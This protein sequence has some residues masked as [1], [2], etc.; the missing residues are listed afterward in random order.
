MM[1][2]ALTMKISCRAGSLAIVALAVLASALLPSTA[3]SYC[4]VIPQPE[5]EF[6]GAAGS[7]NRVFASPGDPVRI[8]LDPAGCESGTSFGSAATLSDFESGGL[9]AWATFGTHAFF[10]NAGRNPPPGRVLFGGD[11]SAGDVASLLAPSQ[12]LGD[13]LARGVNRISWEHWTGFDAGPYLTAP[14]ALIR[15]EGPGGVAEY[16]ADQAE[17]SAIPFEQWGSG[18]DIPIS[19]AGPTGNWQLVSGSWAALL[20]DVDELRILAELKQAAN[21][22]WAIDNFTLHDSASPATTTVLFEPPSGPANAVIIPG[23][24]GD[25]TAFVSQVAACNASLGGGTATCRDDLSPSVQADAIS[26]AFPDTAFVGPTTLAVS[27]SGAALPCALATTECGGPGAPGGLVACIDRIYASDGTCEA[28]P[29]NAHEQFAGVTA[30]PAPNDF[31]DI[32][33]AGNPSVSC[34]NSGADVQ[35]TTDAEGNLVIPVDWRGVLVQPRT[36]PIPRLVQIQSS[37]AA[38]TG[39]PPEAN[40]T[41][42]AP[43]E[44]PGARFLQSLSQ[45]GLRVDPLFNPLSNPTSTD[46]TLFGSTD[47]EIGVIRVLRR[48]PEFRECAA[49]TRGG[50]ACIA[51]FECPS[52][53]CVQALCR[54]GVNDGVACTGDGACPGGEC[55]PSN[56]D[57]SDRYSGGTGP[58]L[59]ASAEYTAEAL[60]PVAIESLAQTD[61]LFAFVRSER[62]EST[63]LNLD[64]DSTDETIIDLKI[65]D[66]AD[67]ADIARRVG[68]T[69]RASARVRDGIYRFPPLAIEDDIAAFLEAERWESPSVLGGLNGDGDRLDTL[70]RVFRIETPAPT[71]L[72][73][74]LDLAVDP[75]AD[76]NGQTLAVSDG[77][78]FFRE[79]ER[80]GASWQVANRSFL[81]DELR[82]SSNQR[83]IAYQNETSSFLEVYDRDDDLD[84]IL[85]EGFVRITV[86]LDTL[87]NPVAGDHHI[88]DI[89]A[90]GRY[91]AFSSDA[92][93][94][95]A[96]DTNGSDDVF[97]HDRDTDEDGIYDEPGFVANVRVSVSSAGVQANNGSSRP[98]MSDDGRFVVFASSATNMIAGDAFLDSELVIHDRDTDEDGIYDE[99]GAIA[100]YR[101]SDAV[102]GVGV[103]PNDDLFTPAEMSRDGRYV[104]FRS[105]ASNLIAGDTNLRSDAFILDRDLDGDGI[106]DESGEA[107]FVSPSLLDTQ[108]IIPT[109]MSD[110]GRVIMGWQPGGLAVIYD[111][112]GDDDGI[113]D[114]PGT[115]SREEVGLSTLGFDT[116]SQGGTL[117]SDGRYALVQPFY[118]G[119]HPSGSFAPQFVDRVTRIFSFFPDGLGNQPDTSGQIQGDAETVFHAK[120]LPG[121]RY[122]RKPA[123][124]G[125]SNDLN[126]DGDSRDTVLAV[127]D[128]QAVGPFTV[129]RFGSA[130]AVS[131]RDGNAAFLADESAAGAGVDHNGDGDFDDLVVQLYRNRQ[132]GPA[133]NLAL[134]A[135]QVAVSSQVV[136]ALASEAQEGLFLNGDGDMDDLVVHLNDTATG[137][138][139]TWQNLFLAADDVQTVGGFVAFTVPEADQGAALNGDGDQL[140]RVLHVYDASGQP[141]A[142]LDDQGVARFNPAVDDFVL[143]E[144]IIA[145]RVSEEGEGVNLNGVVPP[146]VGGVADGDLFDSV[147]HVMDLSTGRTYNGMQAAIPC[148]VEACDPRIPYRVLG[149]KVSFLTLEAQ[150]GGNDLDQS[151]GPLN[152]VIQHFNPEALI[153]GGSMEDA[154]DIV[155]GAVAGICTVT[156]AGCASNAD[157]SGGGECYFPPGGCLFDTGSGC[158]PEVPD[159][160]PGDEFCS[161]VLG[162][163][164]SFTCK[165]ITGPCLTDAECAATE[166]CVDDGLNPEALFATLEEAEDGR[167]RYVTRGRCSDGDGSCD[168]DSQCNEGATCDLGTTTIATAADADGDGLADPIDN[169]QDVANG[170]QL[171]VDGDGIGDAC[172]RQ[173]CGNGIQE[174]G[175]GCDHGSQNGIDGVCDSLCAYVGGG[176]ACSDGIDNDGDGLVDLADAGCDDGADTSERSN[177]LVCDDGRDNDGDYGSDVG[178]DPGCIAPD[179]AREDPACSDGLDNDADGFTD[180]DGGG[181]G[182]PDPQCNGNPYVAKEKAGGCGLGPELIGLLG[183]ARLRRR[184]TRP[185]GSKSAA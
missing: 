164:G 128:T 168:N 19:S 46:T 66:S 52:S 88:G 115:V 111:R 74:G 121:G 185:E 126:G 38:F 75:I 118:F 99:P 161:P 64:G 159:S 72:T 42:G 25:C 122:L 146:I 96:G 81:G 119:G 175:E 36:L 71:E 85:D 16:Q 1:R 5:T 160:C 34:N 95:I 93:N 129:L 135:D 98:R 15:I 58:I 151:G 155:G 112:D 67:S 136:A 101:A 171:D 104:L 27:P 142:F 180:Y 97:I 116:P 44:I 65:D 33:T 157:C 138:S 32:C 9:E 178:G 131:V 113:F 105:T 169:C 51:D 173:S 177:L 174:Y 100:S 53:T 148:P 48:S 124:D 23:P 117:S 172:D 3:A 120:L 17:I 41:P 143:G 45:K 86:S 184:R 26:F 153:A 150:Q 68:G 12:Y 6:R 29:E 55:G 14:V 73:A 125:A 102:L 132:A 123:L 8:A 61:D 82:F 167:Q 77:L 37:I 7:V 127:A 176:N 162:V 134:A 49:G 54:G 21:D 69:G 83:W 130:E 133:V 154:C 50:L 149:T 87:G 76:V 62:L 28:G 59:L 47:A 181:F 183:L 141:V 179:G 78:V 137:T 18:F 63:D 92:S 107:E 40:Q 84:G 56:F 170:D 91:V 166:V 22:W 11:G 70:L 140:D 39:A 24:G 89:S 110:D 139:G 156:A 165:D 31:Q 152:L 103:A 158:N 20:A 13:W 30:L 109:D 10:F 80:G 60:N 2:D 57:F 147:M 108:W 144:D 43:I 182:L 94:L 4:D 114:E 145:F 35:F 106:Y 90:D 163:P 79:S